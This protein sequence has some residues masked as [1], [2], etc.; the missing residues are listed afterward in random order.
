[1]KKQVTDCLHFHSFFFDAFFSYYTNVERGPRGRDDII[2]II[3]TS[4][5]VIEKE[6]LSSLGVEAPRGG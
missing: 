1:M 2:I 5:V 6:S 4:K 3:V